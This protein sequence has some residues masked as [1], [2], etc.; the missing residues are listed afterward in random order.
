MIS[1][2]HTGIVVYNLKKSYKFYKSL[3]LELVSNIIEEGNY[4]NN[5]IGETKLKA[6][7]L[8]LKSKDNIIIEI[9]DY[10]NVKK[11]KAKKP[12]TMITTGTMHM[13]FTVSNI[14]KIFHKLKKNKIFFFSPPLKSIFD[15]VTT[16]FCYDPDY[17]LVQFVQGKQV[18]P[19]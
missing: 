11:K 7:V 13:C 10:L 17:N 16:C 4:F 5:L 8:K 9:I 15:P 14:E 19:K 1:Y 12:K 3:G 2:R 18:G 6:K